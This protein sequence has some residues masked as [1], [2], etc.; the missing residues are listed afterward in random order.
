M[1][2]VTQ[3]L[4]LEST[5]MNN[6]SDSSGVSAGEIARAIAGLTS[7]VITGALID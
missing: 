5:N 3:I 4:P 6:L 7:G 2:N 1:K